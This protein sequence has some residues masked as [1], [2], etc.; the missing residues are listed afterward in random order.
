MDP[1]SIKL[2]VCAKRIKEDG[3]VEDLGELLSSHFQDKEEQC[4]EL[5]QVVLDQT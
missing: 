5:S 4:Q 1:I 2:T 3:T